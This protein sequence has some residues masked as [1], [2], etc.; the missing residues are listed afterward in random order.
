VLAVL[1]VLGTAATAAWA[2]APGKNGKIAFRR[3]LNKKHS[4][5]AL[6]TVNPDGSATRQITHT[7]KVCSTSSRTGRR[8]AD[9]SRFSAST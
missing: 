6:F 7:A 5:G 3:Y 9:R 8:T 1:A 2:T 4:R